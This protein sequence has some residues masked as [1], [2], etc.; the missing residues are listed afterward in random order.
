MDL[1][2][3][4]IEKRDGKHEAFSKEKIKNAIT[5]AYRASDVKEE[6]GVI[7]QVTDAVCNSIDKDIISVEEI[8]DLVEHE[9][10]FRNHHVA[11]KANPES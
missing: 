11:K 7:D 1:D 5:K 4:T 6:S 8:Q 10:M 2:K 9:L 3:I